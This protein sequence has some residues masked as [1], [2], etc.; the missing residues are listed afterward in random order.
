[1]FDVG[2]RIKELR[3]ERNISAKQLAVELGFSQS[4]M[5]ALE[6]GVKKCPLETLE[7]ICEVLGLSLAEFFSTDQ[8][9]KSLPPEIWKLVSKKENHGLLKL[10]QAMTDKNHTTEIIE[11]WILSLD[12]TLESLKKKYDLPPLKG[13]VMWVE[14]DNLPESSRG[15]YTEEEKIAILEK[16][17]KKR[18][19]S[20]FKPPWEK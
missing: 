18:R 4:F 6:K 3:T 20:S 19:D 14:E 10:I 17:K 5:S 15:K 8:E 16:D 9:L 11:E 1:M 12:K 7:N 2:A 13:K